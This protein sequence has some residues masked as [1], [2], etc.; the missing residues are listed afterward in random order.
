MLAALEEDTHPRIRAETHTNLATGLSVSGRPEEAIRHYRQATSLWRQAGDRRGEAAT[1]GIINNRL[2]RSADAEGQA[3]EAFELHKHL[4]DEYGAANSLGTLALACRRRRRYPE[5][6]GHCREVLRLCRKLGLRSLEADTLGEL[7]VTFA[8]N[9]ETQA[10]STAIAQALALVD[11]LGSPGSTGGL[12]NDRGTA[13]R[14]LGEPHAALDRHLAAL[15]AAN[16]PYQLA[17]AHWGAALTQGTTE[18]AAGHR[19]QARALF[20]RLGVPI[21]ARP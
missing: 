21:D 12:L 2:G 8:E 7:A 20:H 5:A 6:I 17:L 16:D 14:L 10:A 9:G 11:E 15:A 4:Q 18:L 1:I 19:E 3:R 13:L